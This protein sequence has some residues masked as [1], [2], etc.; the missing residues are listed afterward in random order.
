MRVRRESAGRPAYTRITKAQVAYPQILA[1]CGA[2]E[3][4][5]AARGLTVAGPCRGVYFADWGAAGPEDPVCDVTF[6]V[7]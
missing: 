2:V 6:P 7:G 5:I 1:A 4:W 3:E